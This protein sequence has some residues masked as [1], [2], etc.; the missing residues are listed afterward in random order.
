M[1]TPSMLLLQ[2]WVL[3]GTGGTSVSSCKRSSLTC[4]MLL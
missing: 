1:C 4:F 3:P 2:G